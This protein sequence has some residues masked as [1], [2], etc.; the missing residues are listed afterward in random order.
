MSAPT[1]RRR[2]TRSVAAIGLSRTKVELLQFY[3]EKE[4]MI[5]IFAFPVVMMVIFASAFG[6]SPNFIEIKGAGI[7]APQYY[8]T[9][10]IATGVMLTSFQAMAISI[11]IERDDGTLKLLRGTPMPPMAY[12]IGKVG[13]VLA[14]TV[15]QIALLLAVARFAYSVALPGTVELWVR[16]A[17]LV[18]LGSAAGTT[19]GIAFSSVPR[20]GRTA[21]AVVTP[22]VLILQFISG[23]YFPYGQLPSWMH[24]VASLFPLKWMAQGMRSVFLP[25]WFVQQE[26]SG[27]FQLGLGALVLTLW[28]VVGLVV[29]TRSF[30]WVV[31]RRA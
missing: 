27:S 15:V 19:L 21:S 12:F 29:A 18:A 3:R 13:Q 11:A 28:L 4:S 22:V 23:V 31:E 20:T 7:S 16:L 9:S 26:P 30:R 5:F 2:G 8:V 6:N 10:M 14:T 24:A 25:G 17:W 1:D